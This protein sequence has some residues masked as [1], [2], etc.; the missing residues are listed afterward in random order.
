MKLIGVLNTQDEASSSTLDIGTG[1][2]PEIQIVKIIGMGEINGGGKDCRL[3]LGVNG[4]GKGYMS[5]VNAGGHY[6]N[7][8][9]D[10][11]GFYLGRSGWLLNATFSFEC[12]LT[13]L[14]GGQVVNML[15]SST[16]AHANN[17]IIGYEAHGFLPVS[18]PMTSPQF[19]LSAGIMRSRAMIYQL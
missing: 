13:Y 17:S 5:Y 4:I 8:E 3:F 7:G 9:W 14:Q 6:G 15:A 12:T 11:T 1:D 19:W 18:G 2:N 10:F 16:F